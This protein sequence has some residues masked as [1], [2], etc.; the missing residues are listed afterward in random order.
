MWERIRWRG[1][2]LLLVLQ[3]AE[4]ASV[5]INADTAG[6]FFRPGGLVSAFFALL[7]R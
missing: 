6:N 3:Q 5:V 1:R 2:S 7:V 4:G